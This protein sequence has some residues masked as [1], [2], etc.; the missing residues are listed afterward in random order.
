M[1]KVIYIL[2]L[3]IMLLSFSACGGEG[4][5]LSGIS[6]KSLEQDISTGTNQTEKNESQEGIKERSEVEDVSDFDC[7]G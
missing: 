2:L 1:K 3:T 4:E 7:R 5:A 6:S